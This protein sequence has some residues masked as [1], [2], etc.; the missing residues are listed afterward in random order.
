[1]AR[2]EKI[3]IHRRDDLESIDTELDQALGLLDDASKKVSELLQVYAAP[4]SPPPEG[5]SIEVL[6]PSAEHVS[7]PDQDQSNRP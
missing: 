3:V 7:N 6:T 1:M 5:D 4:T 2:K